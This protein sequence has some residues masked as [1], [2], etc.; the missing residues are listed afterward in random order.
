MRF[1]PLLAFML[2][3]SFLTPARAWAQQLQCEPCNHAFGRVEVGSSRSFTILLSNTG[4]KYLKILTKSKQGRE[5]RFG[6]FPLPITIRPG[7]TVKL[8]ID[9][10]PTAIGHVTGTFTLFSTARNRRLSIPVEGTGSPGLTVSPSKFNFGNVIVGKS[11]VLSTTLTASHGNVTISSDQVTSSEFSIH[12]LTLPVTILSGHSI[13]ARIR[14]TP[15][16]SG[17]G[18]AKAGYFSNAV[19]SP[20]VEHLTGTGVAPLAHSVDLTW[21]DADPSVVGYDVYRSKTHGGPYQKINT[22][23][24]AST[25]YTDYTVV[26]GTTYYYVTTAVD[27]VGKQSGYSNETK[28]VIPSP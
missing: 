27:G 24:D 21:Q 10:K 26:A 18:S 1:F 3:L 4:T 8:P 23:L 25:T 28:A 15:R 14:F 19:E 7:K 22:A 12:G 13:Q 5:F 2:S 16:Q 11:A 17:T 9:F 20:V 6:Y